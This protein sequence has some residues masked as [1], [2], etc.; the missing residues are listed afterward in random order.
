MT[1]IDN[2]SSS[3]FGSSDLTD[4]ILCSDTRTSSLNM[5]TVTTFWK[6]GLMH[7]ADGWVGFSRNNVLLGNAL[8]SSDLDV[9]E[10]DEL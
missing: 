9:T 10:E 5:N 7:K 4:S 1:G 3:D 6:S 2:Y 8:T